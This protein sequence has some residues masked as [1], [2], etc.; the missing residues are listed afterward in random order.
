MPLYEYRCTSCQTK[1]EVSH[2]VG[3]TAGPCPVCGGEAKRVFSSVGLIFKGS[4]FHTTDYKKS[5]ST[6][7]AKGDGAAKS[8]ETPK[9]DQ[10]AEQKPEQKDT[11]TDQK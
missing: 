7:G 1:F 6:D 5:P 3:G 2:H 4:G 8:G 11:K 9:S 10:K